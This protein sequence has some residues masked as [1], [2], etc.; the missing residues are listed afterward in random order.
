MSEHKPFMVVFKEGA[1]QSAIDEQKQRIESQGGKI[2]QTFDSPIIRGFSATIPDA[3]ASELTTQSTGG[4]HE[5][6]E[7][8]E[9]DSE[10][11]T[12]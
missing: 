3:I 10:V 1:P 11:R 2:K 12:M 5:H 6:I 7:Y 8:L 4:G 9:P